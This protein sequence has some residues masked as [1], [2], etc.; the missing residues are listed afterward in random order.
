M[1][2]ARGNYTVFAPSNEAIGHYLD[3]LY[4]TKGYDITQIPDSTA[5][6]I[7]KN[8]IIDNKD[9]NAY[10]STNFEVGAL[11]TTNM[12]SRLQIDY[13]NEEDGKLITRV[14]TNSKIIT[15]DNEVYN[16]VVHTIDHVI[17]MTRPFAP[18]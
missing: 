2:S 16:G 17:D 3:S 13:A 8:S 12:N 15:P 14:N 9:G 1:L 18:I 6:F 7:A 11:G 4:N 10:L 5:E